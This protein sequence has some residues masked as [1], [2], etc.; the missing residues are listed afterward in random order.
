VAIRSIIA[1]RLD[2]LPAEQRRL[3][4]FAS[5]VGEVFWR[6]VVERL[7]ADDE[8]NATSL[9]DDLELRDLIRRQRGSRIQ[10]DDEYAFKHV[11]I[12]DVAYATLPRAARREHHASVAEFLEETAGF[13]PDSAAILAH[14]WR[15]AGRSE[16]AI[17]YLLTAAEQAGRGWAKEEAMA[18]YDQALGLLRDGDSRRRAVQIKRAVAS[19]AL[20]HL[21]GGDVQAPVR[22]PGFPPAQNA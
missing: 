7:A 22:A 19:V 21:S 5:V 6:S 12:R 4:L 16:R 17:D 9:L 8:W 1:A 11:L 2:A 18:L 3:L 14:H 10:G 20:A 13:A 15:E